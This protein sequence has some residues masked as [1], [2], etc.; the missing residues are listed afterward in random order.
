MAKIRLG[1]DEIVKIISD[2]IR[3]R[4]DFLIHDLTGYLNV[5]KDSNGDNIIEFI[6]ELILNA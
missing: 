1:T 6:A 5:S 3:D 4:E 2:H